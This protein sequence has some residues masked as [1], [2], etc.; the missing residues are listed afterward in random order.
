MKKNYVGSPHISA[1]KGDFA[2]T[3]LL[4]GDPLRAKWIAQTFL[5]NVQEVTA[6][7]GM[8][9]FTG[10]YKNHPVSVMGSGMGIPSCGIYSYELF[11]YYG[12]ENI[13][14]VGT[15]GGYQKN[16]KVGTV[17]VSQKAY[18]ESTYAAMMK[19]ATDEENI[20][21]ASPKLVQ[22]VTETSQE[23]K[24]KTHPGVVHS[25]D[26]FY[27]EMGIKHYQEMGIDAVEMEA[28]A[29]YTNAKKLG[30]NGLAICTISDNIVTGEQLTPAQRQTSLREMVILALEMAIK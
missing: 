14:R 3:V 18:S 11:H 1:Q 9:G 7:R 25:G 15:A 6:V 5:D 22:L 12:V 8:L 29:I 24:I 20:M 2:Q 26:A 13:I 4:P 16:L 17:I 30:K 19:T 28:F 21:H 27:N 10:T 23:L